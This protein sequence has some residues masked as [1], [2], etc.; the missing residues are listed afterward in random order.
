MGIS[1]GRAVSF[2]RLESAGLVG[3][4]F[5]GS[6][7][8]IGG[9]ADGGGG[10]DRRSIDTIS[11]DLHS[12]CSYRQKHDD[13][14]HAIRGT[15]YRTS[16]K[17]NRSPPSIPCHRRNRNRKKKRTDSKNAACRFLAATGDFGRLSDYLTRPQRRRNRA[18]ICRF[19]VQ[20]KR[21]RIHVFCR[22]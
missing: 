7:G 11:P 13:P 1:C 20:T 15:G 3:K 22:F 9:S 14:E 6:L 18:E 5:A 2:E 19:P 12:L 16:T 10:S 17:M 4:S 8:K 21:R